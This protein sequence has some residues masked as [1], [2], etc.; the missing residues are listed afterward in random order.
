[1]FLY[2]KTILI[3]NKKLLYLDMKNKEDMNANII[4]G[5]LGGAG[6]GSICGVTGII[7]GSILGTI[8]MIYLTYRSNKK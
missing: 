7:I 2:K 1:M 4:S 6:F 3:L 5:C 8:L